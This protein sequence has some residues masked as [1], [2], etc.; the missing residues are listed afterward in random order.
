MPEQTKKHPLYTCY[1]QLDQ[2]LMAVALHDGHAVESD[3]LL[4]FALDEADRLR[5]EDPFT[6]ALTECAPTRVV[7]MVSRFQVDLN[8]PESKAVYRVPEDAWGLTLYKKTPPDALFKRALQQHRAFYR[9]LN[10]LVK[11]LLERYPAIVVYD[12]HSYNH[13]REGPDA[14]A[15]D[16]AGNPDVNIGTASIADCKRWAP[17]IEAFTQTWQRHK[18]DGRFLDVRQNVRFKGGRMAR[19]LHRRFPSHVCC[20]SIEL[21]KIFMDEWTGC[22]DQ[23]VYD[24][25]RK[26]LNASVPDVLNALAAM[27]ER[28]Q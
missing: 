7:S 28:R 22:L 14:P 4:C 10:S 25:L 13:R 27:L 5:E 12:I 19:W 1:E 23:A 15:A 21:K 24:D 26:T 3:L 20:L 6:G 2:P 17:I 18:V 9:M 11:R 16:P 8:R